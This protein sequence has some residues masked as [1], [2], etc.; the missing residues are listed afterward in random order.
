VSSVRTCK[1]EKCS[2]TYISRFL[3]LFLLGVRRFWQAPAEVSRAFAHR[4]SN[5]ASRKPELEP[6]T[7]ALAASVGK[8]AVA[9]EHVSDT[10]L[11]PTEKQ[12]GGT[13]PGVAMEKERANLT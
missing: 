1:R 10:E 5:F 8:A 7:R 11:S 2:W 6:T 13:A 4:A 3:T 9:F 12:N